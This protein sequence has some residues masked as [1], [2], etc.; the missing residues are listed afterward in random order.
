[1]F[2]LAKLQHIPQNLASAL[3]HRPCRERHTERRKSEAI[4]LRRAH[5]RVASQLSAPMA[6]RPSGKSETILRKRLGDLPFEHEASFESV[7]P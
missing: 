1:L 2:D 7:R 3:L 6:G 4:E 5:L